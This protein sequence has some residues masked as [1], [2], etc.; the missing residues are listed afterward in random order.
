MQ[1]VAFTHKK[2]RPIRSEALLLNQGPV[3]YCISSYGL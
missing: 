3:E 2:V 1:N